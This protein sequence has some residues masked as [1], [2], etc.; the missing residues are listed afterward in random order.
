MKRIAALRD[1]SD[2]H[3]VALLLAQRCR[4]NPLGA[5]P[6]VMETFRGHIEPHF[7]IEE[8]HLVPALEALGENELVTRIRKDHAAIRALVQAAEPDRAGIVRFGEMLEAHVRFEEREVFE[9]TQHRLA[10]SAL[11]S[12]AE[13]CAAIPRVCP[14]S[15]GR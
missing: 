12:I 5:W 14:T 2:D 9:E 3:H 6:D 1:L 15:L 8:D 7:R 11:R 13:A 4:R 10:S